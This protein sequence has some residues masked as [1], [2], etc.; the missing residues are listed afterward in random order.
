MPPDITESRKIAGLVG[1]TLVALTISEGM[2]FHI[3]AGNIPPVVYL[4]G[5][6]LLVAGLSIVRVHNRWTRGWPVL[7]T[8]VGW[9]AVL[10]GLFRM[11]APEAGQVRKKAPLFA[12]LA[13]LLGVGVLLTIKACGREDSSPR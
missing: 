9:G 10:G 5:T 4:N 8:L 3:W 13:V 6:L 1:P 11:F 12:M 7:V 2:N